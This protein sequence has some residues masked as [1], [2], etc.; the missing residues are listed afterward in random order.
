MNTLVL[1]FYALL[2]FFTVVLLIEFVNKTLGEESK[3]L[4]SI[5]SII[6]K[7]YGY[8]R[9]RFCKKGTEINAD[10]GTIQNNADLYDSSSVWE[11]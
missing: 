7:V 3:I 1:I 10:G 11:D 8:I 2:F 4:D 9:Q 5:I 6:K